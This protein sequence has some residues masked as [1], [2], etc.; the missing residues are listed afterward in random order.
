MSDY[1]V[2]PIKKVL[3]IIKLEMGGGVIGFRKTY[4]NW[5]S[6]TNNLARAK[7]YQMSLEDDVEQNAKSKLSE[8]TGWSEEIA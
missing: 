1:I 5:K 2:N 7:V 8:R 4:I 3:S 6:D